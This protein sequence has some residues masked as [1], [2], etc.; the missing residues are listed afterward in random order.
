MN[1]LMKKGMSII[2][3]LF[4]MMTVFAGCNA[5][6]ASAIAAPVR[7]PGSYMAKNGNLH[8]LSTD[9]AVSAPVE[10]EP[11]DPEATEPVSP[12]ATFEDISLTDLLQD[13]WVRFLEFFDWWTVK[14]NKLFMLIESV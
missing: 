4:L 7:N 11:T 13:L 12:D 14:V 10:S 1:A 6:E 3:V 8:A 2:L 9:D 5:P